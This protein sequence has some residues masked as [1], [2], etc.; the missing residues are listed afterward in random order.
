MTAPAIALGVGV[1]IVLLVYIP[2]I[3]HIVRVMTK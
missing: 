3:R 1:V 2:I